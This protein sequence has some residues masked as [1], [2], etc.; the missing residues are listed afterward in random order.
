[1]V[2]ALLPLYQPPA[3]PEPGL[4]S[5]DL[6]LVRALHHLGRLDEATQWAEHILQQ[7]PSEALADALGTLYLD[8]HRLDEATALYGARLRQGRATAELDLLGGYVTLAE[9]H[10]PEAR[11]HARAGLKLDPASL[12][13]GLAMMQVRTGQRLDFSRPEFAQQGMQV[14]VQQFLAKDPQRA[15]VMVR[16]MEAAGRV[17]AK[18]PGLAV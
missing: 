9:G 12:N 1:M 11:E 17:H 5:T 3:Q 18:G 14:F 2:D 4:A 13:S 7:R 8:T 16:M 15:Q 6:S 10:L